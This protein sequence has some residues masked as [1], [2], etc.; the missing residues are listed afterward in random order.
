MLDIGNVPQQQR[1]IDSA[2]R[3]QG[4]VRTQGD[5]AD[6]HPLVVVL[7]RLA[8]DDPTRRN[9]WTV[10]DHFVLEQAGRWQFAAG[11]GTYGILAFEDANANL[12]Y[13]SGEPFLRGD[14]AKLIACKAGETFAD[15]ALVIPADGRP[16]E[17]GDIDVTALQARPASDQMQAT[18]GEVTAVGEIASLDDP[19]FTDEVGVMG[20][21]RPFDFLFEYRPGIYLLEPYDPQ[22][23]PVLFVHG[24]TGHP[25]NFRSIVGHLDRSRY[26]P[27][28][29]FYPS[30]GHLGLI[31]DH[32]AQTMM[33][34]EAR[35]GFRKFYVVAHSMG[36]LTARGFILRHK[37][38]APRV[39]IPLFISLSTPWAGHKGASYGVEMSPAVV[40]VWYDMAPGSEYLHSLYY[41]D[42]QTR[43]VRVTLA[44][45]T[46]HHLLF[47]F[48]SSSTVAIGEANDDTVTVSSELLWDAQ[49]D[50]VRVYGFDETHMGILD[51]AGALTLIGELMNKAS[52]N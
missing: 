1:K 11:A 16:R 19:R 41:S 7:A 29:Y 35:Y 25:A 22:K 45:G 46:A 13:E 42:P 33:K 14:P 49:R 28:L 9:S 2:C 24:I 37:S 38:L 43:K 50:A 18:L 34:L 40:R 32:L 23:I 3:I 36:G 47:S 31:A 4:S 15:I 26:Q 10:A 44:P 20:L 8:G 27:L 12:R 21:W 39:E 48:K 17:E 52:G 5:K 51:S 6:A 30:G